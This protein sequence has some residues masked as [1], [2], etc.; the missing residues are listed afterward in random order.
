ME[1]FHAKY[2]DGKIFIVSNTY[3][4]TAING[5]IMLSK[6]SGEG[7][8]EIEVLVAPDIPY[9][10][11]EVYFS[12][13]MNYC[14]DYPQI[15]IS[16]ENKNF[17]KVEPNY[18]CLSGKGT[19][20]IATIFSN[21][22]FKIQGNN[23]KFY[24]I[25]PFGGNKIIIISNTDNDFGCDGDITFFVDDLHNPNRTRVKVYQCLEND[26][27]DNCILYATY[28]KINDKTYNINVESILKGSYSLFTWDNVQGVTITKINANTLNVVFDDSV[29][30]SVTISLHNTCEDFALTIRKEFNNFSSIFDVAVKC[31]GIVDRKGGETEISI[32]SQTI[33]ITDDYNKILNDN[34][35]I[36]T[37]CDEI[38]T[39][40]P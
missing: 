13:G 30:D 12:Y 14:T 24:S 16:I 7:N 34:Q 1:S 21:H 29:G 35:M 6:Y 17:F 37:V 19:T 40:D 26:I 23:E 38:I 10:I 25:L 9:G 32:A 5:T 11:G 28:T 39:P 20:A 36:S 33:G 31:N 2:K 22:G 4:N 15:H 27:N 8:A 18:V 3:W